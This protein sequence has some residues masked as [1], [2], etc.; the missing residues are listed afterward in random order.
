VGLNAEASFSCLSL[1]ATEYI[2]W[3]VVRAD[4]PTPVNIWSEEAAVVGVNTI[5]QQS[6]QLVECLQPNGL[7]LV[8]AALTLG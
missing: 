4:S 5:L 7:C 3:S 8:V 2:F 6:V 1:A